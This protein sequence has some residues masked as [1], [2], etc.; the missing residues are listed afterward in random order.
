[1]TQLAR[2][3]FDVYLRDSKRMFFVDEKN[4][5]LNPAS[6]K[7]NSRVYTTVVSLSI[8]DKRSLHPVKDTGGGIN[9]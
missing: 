5:Y 6:S 2:S 8:Q 4:F 3:D 1:V 9:W 7:Q